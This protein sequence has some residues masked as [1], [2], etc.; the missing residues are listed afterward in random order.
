M[1]ENDKDRIKVEKYLNLHQI[2]FEEV[3]ISSLEEE[4]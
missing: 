2:A 3:N 4:R 1:P